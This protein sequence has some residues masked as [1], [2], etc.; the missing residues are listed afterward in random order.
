MHIKA[1]VAAPV[2]LALLGCLLLVR[3]PSA[4]ADARSDCERGIGSPSA[5]AELDLIAQRIDNAESTSTLQLYVIS[6]WPYAKD[7]FQDSSSPGYQ[8]ALGCLVSLD[9][10]NS[11]ISTNISV[12]L[13]G[14]YVRVTVINKNF[15]YDWDTYAPSP[16]RAAYDNQDMR[17][18]FSPDPFLVDFTWESITVKMSG[19]HLETPTPFP[20]SE[21]STGQYMW[22]AVTEHIKNARGKKAEATT[23]INTLPTFT[24][25]PD[26]RM[27]LVFAAE[28]SNQGQAIPF[29]AEQLAILLAMASVLKAR[30]DHGVNTS[31]GMRIVTR[32]LC[33]GAAIIS[34]VQI[35][36]D[37]ASWRLYRFG[38]FSDIIELIDFLV[39]FA[40]IGRWPRAA[41]AR[42]ALTI[43]IVLTIAPFVSLYTSVTWLNF[44]SNDYLLLFAACSFVVFSCVSVLRNIVALLPLEQKMPPAQNRS[45]RQTFMNVII[46]LAMLSIVLQFAIAYNGGSG[47]FGGIYFVNELIRYLIAFGVL[48]VIARNRRPVSVLLVPED[49]LLLALAVGYVMLLSGPQWYA[50]Y[51]FSIVCGIAI[52]TTIIILRL[53]ERRSIIKP[54]KGTLKGKTPEEL[55]LAQRRLTQA[56]KKVSELTSDLKAFENVPLTGEQLRTR[57][58]LQDEMSSLH[59]WPTAEEPAGLSILEKKRRQALGSPGRDQ[60]ADQEFPRSAGPADM[61]LAL[62]PACETEGNLQRAC[63]LAFALAV[64]PASYFAWHGIPLGFSHEGIVVLAGAFISNFWSQ[65]VFWIFPLLALAVAWGVL[66]GRRGTGRGIQ[67][68]LFIVVPLGA[69]AIVNRWL[70]QSATLSIVF[71]CALLLVLLIIMG[72]RLDL[73][74]IGQYQNVSY[75]ELFRGYVR[76]NRVVAATTILLPLVTAGLT[77]WN[78]IDS[79]VLQQKAPVQAP[80]KPSASSGHQSP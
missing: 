1:K 72:L 36:A 25:I 38:T 13:D 24:V 50:G 65:L 41:A 29:D 63:R 21:P 11:A 49:L 48:L 66:A 10:E 54:F 12:S 53:A 16:W 37:I 23:K 39:I 18:A 67:V 76:L 46:G 7:L 44:L 4:S 40:L 19:F 62:G 47:F 56:E 20:A 70:D 52:L 58:L 28:G 32:R 5:T 57:K 61:A 6:S 78:Q 30:G 31:E 64:V 26:R 77:I 14:N 27:K 34:A 55:R 45:A 74:S 3:A 80:A 51:Q 9:D 59:R 60:P 15:I 69:H 33:V 35:A 22:R 8:D 68:W 2:L 42:C 75:F 73:T 17:V 43:I 79:G 71:Q